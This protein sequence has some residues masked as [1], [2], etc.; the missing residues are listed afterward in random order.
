MEAGAR[1]NIIGPQTSLLPLI[2]AD[3]RAALWVLVTIYVA[4]CGA[5]KT[6]ITSVRRRE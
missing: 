2:S 3:S 5:S 6:R 1:A 4:C